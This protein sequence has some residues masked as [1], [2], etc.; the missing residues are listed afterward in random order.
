[1][2]S[3]N[4]DALS[5]D[6]RHRLERNGISRADYESGVAVTK[7]R[8]HEKT[9]ERPERVREGS[10]K[11]Q[12]YA[13]RRKDLIK[14]VLDYKRHL[15][16]DQPKWNEKN[17]RKIIAKHSMASLRRMRTRLINIINDIEDDYDYPEEDDDALKYH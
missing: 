6:Y 10:V 1:M 13:Q 16:G 5:S 14:D 12:E 9:P 15:W 8:G 7:A 11:Y 4:W 17:A 3:R 2:A